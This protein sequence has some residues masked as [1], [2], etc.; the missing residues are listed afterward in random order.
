MSFMHPY[1]FWLMIIPFVIF[2]FLISTNKE[3]LSRI[4]DEKVL[5]RL[6]A[7]DESIPLMMRN[8]IMFLAI[9][10]MIVHWPVR[11]SRRVTRWWK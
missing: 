10:L 1:L 6:S 8:I 11:S 9:F 5:R 7:S 3:R 2:A 4:F